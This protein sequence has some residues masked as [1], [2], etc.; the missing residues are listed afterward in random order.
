MATSKKRIGGHK[1]ANTK[2]K[3]KLKKVQDLANARAG[4]MKDAGLIVRHP[5]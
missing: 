4:H 5:R 1:A 2:L 3:K